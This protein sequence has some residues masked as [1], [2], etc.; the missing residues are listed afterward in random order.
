VEKFSLLGK[1][2]LLTLEDRGGEFDR[3]PEA[4]LVAGIAGGALIELS[5][6]GKLDSDLA[7][8]FERSRAVEK[9]RARASARRST[10]TNTA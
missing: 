7:A 2:L 6:R 4:F 8:R 9:N 1:L 5:L 3:V 10:A